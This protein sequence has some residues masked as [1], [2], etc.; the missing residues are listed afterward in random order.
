MRVSVI[1]PTLNEELTIGRLLN[2]LE[3]E[4]ALEIL[5]ADGGSAD[6]TIQVAE[7]RACVIRCPRGRSTQMNHAARQANGEILLFLHADVRLEKGAIPAVLAAMRDPQ[8]VGGNFRI[9]YD[10][11]DVTAA[12]FTWINRQRYRFGVFYGDSGIFCRKNVFE[13]LGGYAEWPILEDFD[14]AQRLRRRGKL[15]LLPQTIHVSDRRWRR[16]GLLATM[17][18]WFWIQGLYLAGVSPQRLHRMYRDIR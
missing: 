13:E 6:G 17:W 10:G 5:V 18:N 16:G 11:D 15:A 8:T 7:K 12:V 2:S 14:F 4:A 1:I 9:R 3:Q